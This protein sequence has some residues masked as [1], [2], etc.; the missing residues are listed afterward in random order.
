MQRQSLIVNLFKKHSQWDREESLKNPKFIAG[1]LSNCGNLKEL[2]AEWRK[3]PFENAIT[4]KLLSNVDD[5]VDFQE[6]WKVV[7]KLREEHGSP[8]YPDLTVLVSTFMTLP[9]SNADAER[10]FSMLTE[11]VTNLRTHLAQETVDAICDMK[12]GAIANGSVCNNID[13]DHLFLMRSD[14]LYA[15]VHSS[16][17]KLKVSRTEQ[18]LTADELE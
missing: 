3:L 17:K 16:P 10:A 4:G 9:H 15:P 12:S 18:E 5:E 2:K 1:K 11:V 13:G 6:F 7:M 8:K 14:N